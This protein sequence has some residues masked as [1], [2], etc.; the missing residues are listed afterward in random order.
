MAIDDD[1]NYT[2]TGAQLK[3]LVW[4]VKNAQITFSELTTDMY[5]WNYQTKT[6]VDPNCIALWRLQ[7]GFYHAAQNV[8]VATD[9]QGGS[10][11]EEN[12]SFLL[13]EQNGALGVWILTGL[14][15]AKTDADYYGP[16]AFIRSVKTNGDQLDD[17][18]LA[19]VNK[20]TSAY[21]TRALSAKQGK[22]LADKIGV[23]GLLETTTKD[24]LVAAINETIDKSGYYTNEINTNTKWIDGSPIYKKTIDTGTL[25]NNT[26]KTVQHGVG[27]DLKRAIKIEGYAYSPNFGVNMS[28][29]DPE[30]TVQV[31]GIN[32]E[33][34]SS[35]DLSM[36]TESYV[37]LYYTKTQ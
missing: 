33:I 8:Y 26:T 4:Q 20:L 19:I 37:T 2:L 10:S 6:D 7:P 3:E 16:S 22:I 34:K 27:V 23:L 18:R 24:T 9:N 11:V 12:V 25:P 28:M 31:A 36:F 14:E 21:E 15:N 30:I 29:P 32:I 1:K 13:Y 17:F 5:D 35:T